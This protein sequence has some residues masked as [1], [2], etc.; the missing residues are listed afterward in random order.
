M[1]KSLARAF[2]DDPVSLWMLPRANRHARLTAMFALM[3]R[4]QVPLGKTYSTPDCVGTALWTPPGLWRIDPEAMAASAEEYVSI[5]G[6]NLSRAID[7]LAAVEDNHPSEPPHW[8]L[9]ALGT[10]P[11]WQGHGIGGALMQPVLSR[12]D[13]ECLPAYLESSK[14]RNI[15]FYRRFGF[16]VIGE[17]QV[18]NGGPTLWPMWREPKPV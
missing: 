6:P 18:S 5:F 12:A 10:H 2:F 8:Y 13:A 17:I 3:L 16:E 9:A 7:V 14:E 11:D 1:A 15:P 4:L